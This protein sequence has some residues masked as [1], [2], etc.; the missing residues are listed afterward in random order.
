MK[1]NAVCLQPASADKF[2]RCGRQL[3]GSENVSEKRFGSLKL[4][5]LSLH[6]ASEKK[7]SSLK[8][9]S[10]LKKIRQLLKIFLEV[11]KKVS[12]LCIPNGRSV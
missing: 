10:G 2:F 5:Q 1:P 11:C 3:N 8:R 7:Y 4:V 9:I 12:Y 6:P